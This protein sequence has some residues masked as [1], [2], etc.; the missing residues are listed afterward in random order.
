MNSELIKASIEFAERGGDILVKIRNGEDIGQ[1]SK[2]SHDD[3]AEGDIGT[4]DPVTLGDTESHKRMSFGFYKYFPG[5]HVVSEEH[6]EEPDLDTVARP[7][8][9]N[10][11][12]NIP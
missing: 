4:D 3:V 5:I 12:V 9:R 10:R 8:L 11:E 7:S 6:T 1:R 2:G